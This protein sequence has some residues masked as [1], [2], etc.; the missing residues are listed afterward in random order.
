MAEFLPFMALTAK[1]SC[2]H[3]KTAQTRHRDEKKI[4]RMR[5]GAL[6]GIVPNRIGVS[7]NP[8]SFLGTPKKIEKNA[9]GAPGRGHIKREGL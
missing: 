2:I 8:L 3:A 7:P 1:Y 4:E 9:Q 5:G 6:A